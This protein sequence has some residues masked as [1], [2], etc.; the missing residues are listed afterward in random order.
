MHTCELQHAP[1]CA[2]THVGR[3]DLL[4][5]QKTCW[6]KKDTVPDLVAEF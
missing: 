6:Q 5:E 3:N 2:H 1:E 4:L